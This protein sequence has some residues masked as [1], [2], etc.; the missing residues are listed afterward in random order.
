[1]SFPRRRESTGL[2]RPGFSVSFSVIPAQAGIQRLASTGFFRI[3]QC[4]SRAGGNP[5]TLNNRNMKKYYIYILA[6]IRNGTLYIGMTNDLTRRVYE[7]KQ[8]LIKG[9][10]KTYQVH[11]LLYFEEFSEVTDAIVREKRVKKW[12]RKWKIRLIETMNP[13][14]KDLYEGLF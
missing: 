10:T 2:H 4:H 8:G 12:E 14:W 9:F 1:V 5:E 13:E 11:N 7:H 3:L 6:S